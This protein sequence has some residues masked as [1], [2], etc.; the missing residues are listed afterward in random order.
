[1]K[2]DNI[3]KAYVTERDGKIKIIVVYYKS[4]CIRTYEHYY[5]KAV[6]SWIKNAT[7]IENDDD[8][9]SNGRV[10]VKVYRQRYI[11]I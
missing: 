8:I 3:N 2:N 10:T 11:E 1:M 7:L 4:G 6:L 9:L 5:P